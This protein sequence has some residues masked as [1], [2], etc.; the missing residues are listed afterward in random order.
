MRAVRI[1][2]TGLV[3]GVGFRPF[4]YRLAQNYQIRGWISNDNEGLSIH[5]EGNTDS[6]DHFLADIE[7]FAPDAAHIQQVTINETDI[8]GYDSMTILQSANLSNAITEVS[9][10][11]AVCNDCLTDMRLQ[12]RRLA[13]PFTNCTNCGPRF[14]IIRA[15]PYDRHMTTMDVFEMCHYCQTEYHQ[16]TDR[17][18]HAQPIACNHCGP[19]YTMADHHGNFKPLSDPAAAIAN[20]IDQ[21]EIVALKAMGGYHLICDATNEKTVHKLRERKNKEAKPMAVMTTAE[22]LKERFN[23]SEEVFN[24]LNS[25]K[26]PI[27]ILPHKYPY[28][29]SVSNGLNTTGI[30]LPYMP[31]HHQLFDFMQAEAIVLTSGNLSDEPITITDADAYQNLGKLTD[32]IVGY[33]REIHNRVDDSVFM[34]CNEQ[35]VMIRRSR[36]FAPAPVSLHIETEGILAMGAEMACT[37]AIGKGRQ[38]LLSQHIG[39]LKNAATLAFY[40]EA[41][42][43]LSR[44]FRFEPIWI[45]CDTHPDYLSSQIARKYGI[46]VIEVQ[47]H[48]A[49]IAAVMAE[50]FIDEPVIGIAFDG[51]GAGGDGTIWGGEFLIC[52]LS[53]YQRIIY[54][55]PIPLPG[56]DKVVSEPWRTTVS[57]LYKYFGAEIVKTATNFLPSPTKDKIPLM[58][59]AID[60]NLNCPASSGAGR[61]FDAVSALLNICT[62]S[63]Y[64]AEAPMRLEAAIDHGC[65]ESYQADFIEDRIE[66]KTVFQSILDDLKK[67]T[68]TGIIAAKFHN[69]ML[70]LIKETAVRIREKHQLNKVVLSGG[71]FQ[72]RYL[73]EHSIRLLKQ[74]G[75]EVFFPQQIPPNDGGIALGQIAVA[76][77]LIQKRK[78]S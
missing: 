43:R 66:F 73:L 19:V 37:F 71:S 16:P 6:I 72:N 49:H 58:L 75:F 40:E 69:T 17:R 62:H 8:F 31:L 14:T 24:L 50:H 27:G 9:P 7:R 34:V 59:Q 55:D 44:L 18:F 21:G 32:K 1:H 20:W 54:F 46:E 3:Q 41:L 48:H 36:G 47:H 64:H 42:E 63:K 29:P 39:D 33:N 10:D 4:V 67:Q 60:L 52:E 5:A 12:H 11:I 15:L 68:S 30:V 53:Q 28:S 25:W 78:S 2:I 57:Y 26:R 38:A 51:T 23:V 45:A 77:K 74:C 13:Y 56:G 35:P 76:A 65:A 70:N 22:R 61:L